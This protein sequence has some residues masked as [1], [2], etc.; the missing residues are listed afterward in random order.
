MSK[1]VGGR[2]VSDVSFRLIASLV[3][4]EVLVTTERRAEIDAFFSVVPCDLHGAFFVSSPRSVNFVNAAVVE[5]IEVGP[6]KINIRAACG[7]VV[8]SFVD[9]L[10]GV[11]LV[12]EAFKSTVML[13]V[14]VVG[15]FL[16]EN[17]GASI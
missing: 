16:S 1:G 7:D 15:V 3:G 6:E 2:H 17:F 10:V 8:P 12:I 11:L 5:V 13:G 14:S 9:S 4:Q